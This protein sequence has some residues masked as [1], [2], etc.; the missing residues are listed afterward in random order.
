LQSLATGIKYFSRFYIRRKP[1]WLW[2]EGLDSVIELQNFLFHLDFVVL[3]VLGLSLFLLLLKHHDLIDQRLPHL[4]DLY[5]DFLSFESLRAQLSEVWNLNCI[6]CE[7]KAQLFVLFE[8]IVQFVE[9]YFEHPD[10]IRVF[11][12]LILQFL[13]FT[14]KL[15]LRLAFFF[16]IHG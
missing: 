2:G 6:R 5:N 15:E 14:S 12:S 8:N 9:L 16:T 10:V 11:V 7:A 1:N 13:Y 4:S 3:H